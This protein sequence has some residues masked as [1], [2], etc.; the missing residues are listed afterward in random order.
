[1]LKVIVLSV[2]MLRVMAPRPDWPDTHPELPCLLKLVYNN[3]IADGAATF[4]IMT[5]SITTLII[6]TL[7]L[8]T[9]SITTLGIMTLSITMN[10]T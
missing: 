4:S 1:M 10:K 2:N 9:F 3:R 7:S 8:T 5:L 6:T